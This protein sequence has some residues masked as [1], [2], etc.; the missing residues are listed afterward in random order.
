MN[1]NHAGLLATIIG[2]VFAMLGGLL[3]FFVFLAGGSLNSR[4][5]LAAVGLYF[6]GKGIVALG[7]GILTF[8]QTGTKLIPGKSP[9][10]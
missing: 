7:L 5:A 4:G 9:D 6:L 10:A 1:I 8:G 3:A 2:G